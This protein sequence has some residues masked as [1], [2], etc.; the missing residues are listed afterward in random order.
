VY[1]PYRP[2]RKLGFMRLLGWFSARV[3]LGSCSCGAVLCFAVPYGVRCFAPLPRGFALFMAM[4][5]TTR[6]ELF[7]LLA[8]VEVLYPTKIPAQL[9]A[10]GNCLSATAR[11]TSL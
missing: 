5:S 6:E 3:V 7:G 11:K 8:C 10:F 2:R 4:G 1:L 9:L